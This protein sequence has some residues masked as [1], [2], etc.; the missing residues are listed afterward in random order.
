MVRSPRSATYANQPNFQGFSDPI[1][2]VGS[3]PDLDDFTIRIEDD[4][5]NVYV[6]T[7]SRLGDSVG[8][9]GFAGYRV[10]QGSIWQAKSDS[11]PV[12]SCALH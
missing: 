4:L 1:T 7:A 11:K 12:D 10:E 3:T 8:R 5:D 9:T 2:F 6:G